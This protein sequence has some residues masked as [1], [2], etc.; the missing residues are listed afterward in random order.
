MSQV[1]TL[2]LFNN[3]LADI[4]LITS[5]P[6]CTRIFSAL[7][8]SDPPIDANNMCFLGGPTP[9]M[10]TAYTGSRRRTYYCRVSGCQF[11]ATTRL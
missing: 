1:V 7:A 3:V 10:T 9:G 2:P 6:N 8:M 4:R 5:V 11:A